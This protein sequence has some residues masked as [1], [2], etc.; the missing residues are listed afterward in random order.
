M[1]DGE[2]DIRALSETTIQRIAAGEVVERPSS[3]VKELVE[4]S[5]DADA[6][7]ISVQVDGG[8]TERI[9]VTDDGTG[10]S[11]ADV[12]VAVEEHT[13]SKIRDIDD[14]EAGV[15]TLGFRG[16][17][18]YTIGAVSRTKIRTKPR[19]GDTGT[20]LRLVG[21]E[22]EA[23]GPAGCPEGTTIE[24]TDLFFNTPA[25]RKY[26]KTESTEF[27][28]VNRVV[29]Q[30]ALA[31]PDVAFS[32]EHDGRDVFSTTGQ[33][34]LQSTILSV[35]GREV[36]TAMIPVEG[37]AEVSVSGHV[38]H[39]ETT[40]STREYVAT[41]VNGRY[42]RSAVIREAILDAYGNQLAPDRYPFAVLFL[43]VPGD[44]VDVN[45]HPRKMEVRFGDERRVKTAV[46]E[47]VE[48]ALLDN[49]L[50]RS[51]APRGRSAPDEADVA[52]EPVQSNFEDEDEEPADAGSTLED[53]GTTS[54]SEPPR[55]TSDP[56]DGRS[57]ARDSPPTGTGQTEQTGQTG[58]AGRTGRAASAGADTARS[59][60]DAGSVSNAESNGSE[61][62]GSTSSASNRTATAEG[63]PTD[64]ADD[65]APRTNATGSAST[66]E[67]E[68]KF[69]AATAAT[70]L[71]GTGG[72]TQRE[73]ERL[74]SMRILGQLHDT[75][76]VAET[77][78][79][80]VLID[81]HAADERV[82]YERLCREFAGET[83]SQVL[84]SSVELELTAAEAALFEEYQEALARLGFHAALV[85][86]RTVEV[87]TVPAVFE[88]TLSPEL[89]RDVL[90]EFIS[91]ESD[92]RE[93]NSAEAVADELISDLACY[94]SITGNTSL[95]EGDVVSLLAALDECD[96][97][98][99][100][101]HGRPVVIELNRGEIE[102]RFERDYP[103]HT[104]RR[105]E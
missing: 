82:N 46:R 98:Y 84:A 77:G 17:A 7:R 52:P 28:H 5:L 81:Q 24:V 3:V 44:A 76:V 20:E 43:D 12:Q 9:A 22:V 6:S 94:P 41:Y 78:D 40:R 65:S 83:T 26:L 74:P 90:N 38:S 72:E 23:V 37:D 73:F 64:D 62:S 95:R 61:A 86:D 45:V 4:N 67:P 34:N 71:S 88:K 32:L 103:G 47:A 30:Y 105:S 93:G 53:E 104:G 54:T 96:N 35:Y 49:G 100:C 99:A 101:P 58:Q 80:L 75:Y 60:S 66:S 21:G 92:E 18:L 48:D 27:A 69:G 19:G 16:E 33:G 57:A 25:R 59:A 2:T 39:P 36:A 55:T 11:K 85:D 91:T 15:S 29:T 70:T 63:T 42:V 68:R 102:D 13:T 97:P 8:G 14:L 79:G 56:T 1:S 87:T 89:L 50:I 10:M 51:S 31:N